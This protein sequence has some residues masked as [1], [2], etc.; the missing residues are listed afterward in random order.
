MSMNGKRLI[1]CPLAFQSDNVDMLK[2]Q[3]VSI[4]NSFMNTFTEDRNAKE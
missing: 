3:I 1:K 2:M 4:Q